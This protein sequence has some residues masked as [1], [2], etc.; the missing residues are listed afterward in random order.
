M[1]TGTI[2]RQFF[3]AS[4]DDEL[5]WGR[6]GSGNFLASVSQNGAFRLWDLTA[7]KVFG[8]TEGFGLRI[9]TIEFSMDDK[10]LAVA[11]E[12]STIMLCEFLSGH[13][14]QTFY[15]QGTVVAFSRDCRLLATVFGPK[16]QT[17]KT[18]EVATGKAV[19][20][21]TG[22]TEKVLSMVFSRDNKFLASSSEDCTVKIW[23]HDIGQLRHTVT[24]FGHKSHTL[25]FY[26]GNMLF[27]CEELK[28]QL[29]API[30]GKKF[31]ISTNFGLCP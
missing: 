22:H 21:L 11:Y 2:L 4:G 23:D 16:S 20:T 19:H 10:F 26:A 18:W 31:S 1:A 12:D 15:E 27:I 6:S 3:V 25:T 14:I 28:A 29:F 30:Q 5:F 9:R 24:D 8:S 7:G 17:V 13:V